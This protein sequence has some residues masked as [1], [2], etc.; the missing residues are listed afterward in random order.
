MIDEK[1]WRALVRA[2]RKDHAAEWGDD[3]WQRLLA[4][5][6]RR[7]GELMSVREELQRKIRTAAEETA[8]KRRRLK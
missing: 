1:D 8:R 5:T 3:T 7:I 2:S 6:D 4:I